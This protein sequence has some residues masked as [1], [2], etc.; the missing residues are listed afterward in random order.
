MCMSVCVY[1]CL[2]VYVCI[3][4]SMYVYV[5]ECVCLCVF[6]CVCM[7]VCV[8]VYVYVCVYTHVIGYLQR[9]EESIRSPG[10]EVRDARELPDM[11]SLQE[12]QG[13]LTLDHI[14]SFCLPNASVQLPHWTTCPYL[15]HFR[16]SCAS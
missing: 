4:E 13:S 8:C 9:K 15:L 12:Q 6:V 1:V 2:C 7:Y 10:A 11:D 14:A 16:N 3:C 5:C